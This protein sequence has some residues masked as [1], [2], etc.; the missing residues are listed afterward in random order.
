[1][2]KNTTNPLSNIASLIRWLGKMA[3]A[4]KVGGVPWI[5]TL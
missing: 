1:M 3:L 2:P 4:P 5:E